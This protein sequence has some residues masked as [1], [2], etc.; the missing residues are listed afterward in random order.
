M[1]C[2]MTASCVKRAKHSK[3]SVLP[4]APRNSLL[5]LS[6]G[7][8]R[9]LE[10]AMCLAIGPQLLLLDEPLAGMGTEESAKMV[11]SSGGWRQI[12]RC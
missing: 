4:L 9:Q 6:H 1:L 8:Q 12:T 2:P 5:A 7:E 3:P 10:I 11:A